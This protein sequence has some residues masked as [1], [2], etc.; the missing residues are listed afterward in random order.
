MNK[1]IIFTSAIL[2]TYSLE[3]Q[4]N[5]R[6][7]EVTIV[8]DTVNIKLT[9]IIIEFKKEIEILK[10]VNQRLDSVINVLPRRAK[11]KLKRTQS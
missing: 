5:L 7:K 11:K 4:I 10:R 6:V 1:L 3:A 2:I 8:T 9:Q